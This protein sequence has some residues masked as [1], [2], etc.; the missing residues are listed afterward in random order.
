MAIFSHS[1]FVPVFLGK[2]VR[3]NL[4]QPFFAILNSYQS[5]WEKLSEK[6]GTAIFGHSKLIP[7]FF[8]KNCQ[9]KFGTATFGHSELIP[10]FLGKLVRKNLEQPLLATLN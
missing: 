10:V 4:E 3:K 5:F 6:I 9:K 1:E 2:I 7:V 8:G